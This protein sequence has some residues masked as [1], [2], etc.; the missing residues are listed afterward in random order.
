MEYIVKE[1]KELLNYLIEDLKIDRKRSKAILANKSILINNKIITKYNYLL[2]INDKILINKKNKTDL[3]II[4]EDKD[5][6]V[7]NKDTNLLTISTENEKEKT[8][9]HMVSEYVKQK[10][11]N[12]KI[13]VIH[14]LD[15]DTSGIVM[16]AKSLKIKE[17]YQN[18]WDDL[19]KKRKYYAVVN[20]ILESGYIET[21]LK[22]DKNHFVYSSKTG[23]IAKT[24][25]KAL[26]TNNNTL[27]D[28]N[29]LTGRK[30]Q[31]RVHMKD[32]NHSI[33]GDKKYG[34]VK[35]KRMYLHAYELDIINPVTKKLMI[36]KLDLPKSFKEVI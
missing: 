4:Y 15:K 32:L 14:R 5:I 21:Y 36:F 12:N 6:I 22:E 10:N 31:I 25:Y 7:L 18:N 11:K 20:G 9:Y 24:E 26:K 2:N 35:G 34:N 27:L 17:L 33:I 29:I 30:N 28:I 1:K 19:V 16:F 23:K 3:E 8:L 13:F